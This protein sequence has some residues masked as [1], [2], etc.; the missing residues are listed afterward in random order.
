[1]NSK[2]ES[3][4]QYLLEL[5]ETDRVMMQNLRQSILKALPQGYIEVMQYGMISY[6]VP[7]TMFPQGY[8]NDPSVPLPYVSLAKQKNHFAFYAM[9]LYALE[10]LFDKEKKR[11]E[12]QRGKLDHGMACIRFKSEKK[13]DFELIEKIT[14]AMPIKTYIEYYCKARLG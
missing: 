12:A 2:A 1:M 8:L 13:I 6:V 10:E 4:E 11:Y 5:N 14:Q 9:S 3:V 7:L